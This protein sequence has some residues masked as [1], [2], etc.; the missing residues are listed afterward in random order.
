[1]DMKTLEEIKKAMKD[2]ADAQECIA[3][4]DT[5]IA[6]SPADDEA[7]LTRGM[8][9]WRLSHRA[10]AINDLNAALRVNPDSRATVMLQS[11]N[12]ILD[13]YDK[14]LYNP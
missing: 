1:M 10:E 9:H 2:G 6:V 8:L 5:L 12:T 4:L 7:L 3:A 13:F 14:D 11:V